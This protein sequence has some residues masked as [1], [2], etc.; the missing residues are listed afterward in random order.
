MNGS[1]RMPE[2]AQ[3]QRVFI[4]RKF[5]SISDSWTEHSDATFDEVVEKASKRVADRTSG[6]SVLDVVELV[7][8]RRVRV[9]AVVSTV[10]VTEA[11]TEAAS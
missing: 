4:V 7:E 3:P 5:G 6:A 8:V 10:E 11:P 9:E 2:F 1:E